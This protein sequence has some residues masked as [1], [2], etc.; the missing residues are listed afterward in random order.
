M[1]DDLMENY[2]RSIA[3]FEHKLLL[4]L[5]PHPMDETEAREF[6]KAN[7]IQFIVFPDGRQELHGFGTKLGDVFCGTE[8]HD[9][10]KG[11]RFVTRFTPVPGCVAAWN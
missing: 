3:E 11:I 7:G 2:R 8:A 1:I 5:L 9:T 10:E 6:V 4:S